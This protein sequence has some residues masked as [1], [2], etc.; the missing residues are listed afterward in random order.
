MTSRALPVRSPTV[1]SNLGTAM[2][3]RS[4]VRHRN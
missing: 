1:G 3:T 2:C 4:M